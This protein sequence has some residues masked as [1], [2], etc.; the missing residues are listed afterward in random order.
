MECLEL[1]VK[2]MAQEIGVIF[3]IFDALKIL[4]SLG[5]VP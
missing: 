4:E 3:L 5:H 2:G 1:Y